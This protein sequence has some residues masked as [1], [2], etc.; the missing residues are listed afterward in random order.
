MY[1]IFLGIVYKSERSF[2]F[3]LR[4]K[5]NLAPLKSSILKCKQAAVGNVMYGAV[6]GCFSPK[7]DLCITK[8][9]PTENCCTNFGHSYQLPHGYFKGTD[10]A[11]CLLAG[12][13]EFIPS[14]IE[15]F[16]QVKN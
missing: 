7:P 3:S 15:V 14:E 4:N 10:K 12:E 5:D 13:Y 9:P 1:I 11:R 8:Y 6:F 2:I 16:Y